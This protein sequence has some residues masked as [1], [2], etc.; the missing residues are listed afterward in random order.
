MQR[1]ICCRGQQ[2]TGKEIVCGNQNRET[3]SHGAGNLGAQDPRRSTASS[4]A[5]AMGTRHPVGAQR[6]QAETE[7]GTEKDRE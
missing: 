2:R 1:K 7:R 3:S 5:G 6:S 4:G